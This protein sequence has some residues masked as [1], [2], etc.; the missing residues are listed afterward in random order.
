[1]LPRRGSGQ[2]NTAPGNAGGF[3]PGSN[4]APVAA[5][6]GPQQPPTPQA[7]SQEAPVAV[8]AVVYEQNVD[9]PSII[10]RASD[11]A[12]EHVFPVFSASFEPI[13]ASFANAAAQPRAL[14]DN[15][16]SRPE[17]VASMPRMF[18]DSANSCPACL[19]VAGT[20][21]PARAG[22]AAAGAAKR[23]PSGSPSGPLNAA[24]EVVDGIPDVIYRGGSPSPSNLKP[25]PDDNGKLSFRDSLSNPWPKLPD[26]RPP[27]G[28]GPYFPVD[29]SLLPS[30]S[31]IPDGIAGSSKTPP[32]HVSVFDVDPA[33]LRE[34]V[35]DAA[36]GKFPK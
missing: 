31:V 10:Q 27:L 13:G 23:A 20:F 3:D 22:A 8:A 26:Q 25:R 6:L 19:D 7:A 34:A 36:R 14:L 17:F 9:E 1:V 11:A 18:L 28:P 30:G 5:P 33:V 21:L 29:T 12:N 15:L 32:G 24:G 16:L 2:A 4:P 35:I